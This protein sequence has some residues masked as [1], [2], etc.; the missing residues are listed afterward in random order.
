MDQDQ[1]RETL[2]AQISALVRARRDSP[3]PDEKA[4]A[5]QAIAQ[6]ENEV[7]LLD[8]TAADALPAKVEAIIASLDQVLNAHSLDAASALGRSIGRIRDM[9]RQG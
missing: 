9:A 3:D 8:L 1:V 6:L 2:E 4:A 5:T 7:N